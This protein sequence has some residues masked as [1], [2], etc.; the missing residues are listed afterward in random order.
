MRAIA[1]RPGVAD[2]TT[3]T[4][5]DFSYRLHSDQP[6]VCEIPDA[7]LVGQY[8]LGFTD[9]HDL[10]LELQGDRTRNAIDLL[11]QTRREM[12]GT[13][14][15]RRALDG[16]DTSWDA[17]EFDLATSMVMRRTKTLSGSTVEPGPRPNNYFHWMMEE[18][19]KL[20][21][22][23]HYEAQTGQRPTLLIDPEP[24]SWVTE[25]LELCGY[26]DS[27]W[28]EWTRPNAAVETLVVPSKMIV[29]SSITEPSLENFEWVR[30]RILNAVDV[31]SLGA[32]FSDRIWLSRAG[33]DRRNVRNEGEVMDRLG[34]L[35]FESIRP[36]EH[37]VAEQAAMMAQADAVV[38]AF[39]SSFTNLAFASN[40]SVVAVLPKH[41]YGAL[42]H[43][44]S[45]I[46]G[47]D[48]EVVFSARD[49]G[50]DPNPWNQDIYVD[51]DE[52]AA[53]VT[54]SLDGSQ[55]GVTEAR[56]KD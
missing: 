15:I 30:D 52:L 4:Q 48:Y 27:D 2:P 45:E 37:S 42:E 49:V 38:G 16:S 5:R 55:Q 53:A 39:G 13:D 56:N 44:F 1:A 21:A 28:V 51:V 32:A 33:I 18:L 26:D 24:S 41:F 31:E 10:I 22:I 20:R 6:F 40:T 7:T 25:T 46:L 12:G 23:E 17:T 54:A 14:E 29:S 8:A 47:H 19:P 43:E 11:L 34:P 35:G 36:E 3:D 9:E 50:G